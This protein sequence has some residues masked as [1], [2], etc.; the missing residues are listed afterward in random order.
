MTSKVHV[1]NRQTDRQTDRMRVLCSDGEA[2]MC[3]GRSEQ[4]TLYRNDM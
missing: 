2:E 3:A 1:C 4:V